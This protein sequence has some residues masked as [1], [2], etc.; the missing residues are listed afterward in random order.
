MGTAMGMPMAPN[1]VN[2]F[3]AHYKLKCVFILHVFVYKKL[4]IGV[5]SSVSKILPLLEGSKFHKGFVILA[6]FGKFY[7]KFEDF[8]ALYTKSLLD[9]G[10]EP[11][12]FVNF[13]VLEDLVSYRSVSY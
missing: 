7:A 10:R 4:G 8:F 12:H 11:S 5:N 9:F 3:M 13:S 1:N 6:I 2:L